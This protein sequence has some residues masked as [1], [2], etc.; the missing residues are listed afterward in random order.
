MGS[1][2]AL[3]TSAVMKSAH[4]TSICLGA[5]HVVALGA[6]SSPT[7]NAL[8]YDRGLDTWET[9][10]G[11]R[12]EEVP[13]PALDEASDYRDAQM[14]LIRPRFTGFCGTDRGIWFRRAM[15]DMIYESLERDHKDQRVIG[16]EL[17]G[18]VAAV[19]SSAARDLGL[20]PGDHVSTESHIICG[21]CYQCRIGDTHVCADN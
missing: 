14:A 11:L 15:K 13:A 4:P 10:R 18:E 17:F 3:G 20:R 1:R 12:R 5:S 6:M 2:K 8:V 19:G 7:M 9:T 21:Q 16:H